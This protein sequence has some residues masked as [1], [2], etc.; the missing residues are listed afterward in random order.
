MNNLCL[1]ILSSI[2]RR[3][4]FSGFCAAELAGNCIG[5]T[6]QGDEINPMKFKNKKWDVGIL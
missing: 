3:I 4:E 1:L 5:G 6:A 2:L